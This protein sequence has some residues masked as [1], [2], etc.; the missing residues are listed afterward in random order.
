MMASLDT[1]FMPHSS[2]VYLDEGVYL[3]ALGTYISIK[4]ELVAF[5]QK[6]SFETIL[7]RSRIGAFIT[8]ILIKDWVQV[9]GENELLKEKKKDMEIMDM[10]FSERV[11]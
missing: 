10:G 11:P 3:N 9:S 4:S 8:G 7:V 5:M 1:T 2:S 6:K